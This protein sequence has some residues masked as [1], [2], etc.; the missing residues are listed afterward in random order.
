[1]GKLLPAYVGF[2]ETLAK[3]RRNF[4][5]GTRVF[6]GVAETEKGP[7]SRAFLQNLPRIMG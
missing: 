1:M 2:E 6:A 5:A 4:T 3:I 7:L